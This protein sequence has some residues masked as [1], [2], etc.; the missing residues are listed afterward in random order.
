VRE[1]FDGVAAVESLGKATADGALS[2]TV[3][4]ETVELESETVT[5]LRDVIAKTVE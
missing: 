2:L 1:A 3:G 4:D 5:D